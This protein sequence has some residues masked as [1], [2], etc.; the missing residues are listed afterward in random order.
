MP[1]SLARRRPA[2]QA[3]RIDRLA[4]PIYRGDMH[5]S[6]DPS[7]P[8]PDRYRAFAEVESR[9]MSATYEGWALGAADDPATLRLID[10]LPPAKRQPNLVFASARFQGV[11]AGPYSLFRE[12]LH[13]HWVEVRATALTHA[14]Q[15]NEAA[16]CALHLPVLARLNGP[17]ALLEVGASAGLCLYPDRYSYRYTGHPQLDPVDGPSEVVLDCEASADVPIPARLPDVV[18]RAG[19]DLNPLDVRRPDDLAWLDALI[20]PEHDDRRTR[21]QA[22][23]RIAAADPP[24][25]V[26]GDLN[27]RLAGLAAEAPPDATLVVF[28]TA[29]LAYLDEAARAE[30]V[31]TVRGLPGHWVSVE[32]RTIVPGI[33]ARE[34]SALNGTEFVLALDAEQLA[35]AQPHGRALRWVANP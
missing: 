31:G 32:G 7:A 4:P 26:A 11:P 30:F 8:T 14:T 16:R 18:W 15:T 22:A 19:I 34:D 9:G 27:E 10:E 23:A 25:I 2:Q 6:V 28:H 1:I 12:W 35:W 20:W 13:A 5:T 17:L 21:L 24:H 3:L 29:V 33:A